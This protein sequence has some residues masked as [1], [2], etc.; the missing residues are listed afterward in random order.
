M[1][2]STRRPGGRRLMAIAS[3]SLLGI[4]LQ[5]AAVLAD[6]ASEIR[7]EILSSSAYARENLKDRDSGVSSQGSLQFWSSGGLIQ[8]VPG[9]GS[10]ATYESFTLTPKHVQVITLEEGKSAVAMYYS[11]GSYHITG[12]EPVAHYMTR[13]T[14]VY[15]K[16]GGQWKVRAAHFSPIAGGSGTN[17][18]AVDD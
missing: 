6:T 14:E 16:E 13:V 15:V 9:D 1:R 12:S 5:P 4:A 8:E 11:E 10:L 7:D 3:I 17:Q 2:I 18:N